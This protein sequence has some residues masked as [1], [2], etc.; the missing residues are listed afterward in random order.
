MTYT[1]FI[2][3]YIEQQ[4]QGTPIYISEVANTVAEKYGIDRK[5]AAAATSVAVK[6]II[7]SDVLADLRC[8]QKGIYYRTVA[9]PFGELEINKET[10]IANRYINP[11]RGYVAGLRLLYHLG[12]T[13]QIPTEYMIATNV[14]KE[15]VRYDNRLGVVI[16]PPKTMINAENRAYLQTLDALDILDKA[17]VDA[18]SPYALLGNH[19]RQNG[20]QYEKLLYYADKYYNQKTIIRLAHTAS[21]KVE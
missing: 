2:H 19:I 5:K 14:A 10:L 9:T 12:L 1:E 4:E 17:P 3:N 13:T 7:D 21:R 6:R 11:E 8:Y 16:R 20:L 18:E 15:C